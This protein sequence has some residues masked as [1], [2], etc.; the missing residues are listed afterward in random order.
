MKEAHIEHGNQV[1]E[2][3]NEVRLHDLLVCCL[4]NGYSSAADENL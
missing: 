2:R 1:A 4:I 3:A